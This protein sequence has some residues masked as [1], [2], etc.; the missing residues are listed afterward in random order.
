MGDCRL[1]SACLA[2]GRGR[3]REVAGDLSRGGRAVAKG[4]H[5]RGGG[6][7]G[8]HNK[9]ACCM[10][11]ERMDRRVRLQDRHCAVGAL[12]H[13][14]GQVRTRGPKTHLARQS[15]GRASQP[16]AAGGQ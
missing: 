13:G 5:G 14:E 6:R 7:E 4:A 10:F 3:R 9:R 16:R 11:A 12:I 2:C 1:C 15:G 8:F